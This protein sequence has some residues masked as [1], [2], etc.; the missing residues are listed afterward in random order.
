MRTARMVYIYKKKEVMMLAER[1]WS[2]DR[3]PV[4]YEDNHPKAVMVDMETFEKIGMIL[5]NLMN[6]EAEAEDRLLSSSGLLEKLM[7]EAWKTMPSQDWREEL[8]EL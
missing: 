7:S 4:V 8:D 6:R 5:D 1:F 2:E 3:F